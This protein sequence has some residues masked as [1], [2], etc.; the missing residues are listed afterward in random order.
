MKVLIMGLNW[1]GDI[2]MSAPALTKAAQKY[3]KVDILTRPH[4]AEVYNFIPGINKVISFPT[5]GSLPQIFKHIKQVRKEKYDKIFILPCSLRTAAIAFLCG[6]KETIG[7]A[8][9]G[10]S[11]LLSSAIKK[12]DNYTKIHEAKLHAKLVLESTIEDAMPSIMPPVRSNKDIAKTM[13]KIGLQPDQAFF[14]MAPGAA[15]GG[16]KRWPPEYFAQLANKI[17]AKYNAPTL[18]T[19]AKADIEVVEQIE[20]LADKTTI[21]LVSKTSIKE[22]LFLLSAAKAVIANDSG[23]MHLAALWQTPTLVP[24]GPTD[25]VRTGPLN[26]F[27][28]TITGT[29]CPITPCRKRECSRDD[30]ICMRSISPDRMFEELQKLV[31][32]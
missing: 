24:V 9:E 13:Q 21:N 1:I 12:P 7:Y 6:A 2:V 28:A 29:P 26:E 20:K 30:H 23:T 4:L 19:G 32:N 17:Y 5:N 18:L 10:R 25:M 15:F 31:K 3:E 16:A 27:A 14:I 11:I 22:L 8:H